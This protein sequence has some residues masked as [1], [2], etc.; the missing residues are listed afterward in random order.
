VI[1]TPRDLPGFRDLLGDGS[2]WA[3]GFAT[4]SSRDRK[5]SPGPA[6]RREFL[7]ATAAA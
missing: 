5:A 2:Q 1:S 7:A 3:S 6:D 4:P